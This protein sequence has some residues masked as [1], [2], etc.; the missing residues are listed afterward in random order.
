M[1]RFARPLCVTSLLF[2]LAGAGLIFSPRT[3]QVSA[4]PKPGTFWNVDDIRPGMKGTGLTVMK[5]TKIESFD[6]EVIGVLKNTNPG[7][8]MVLCRLSGLGLEKTGV[9]QGMSGSPVYVDNKLVGAVAYAWAFGKEPLAGVT[10]FSQMHE[11][12]ASYEKRDLAEKGGPKRIG[13]AKP[14]QLDGRSFDAVTVAQDFSEPDKTAA[15]GLWMI[16]LRTPI[17]ASNM[18]A[19]SLSFLKDTFAS[20][21]MVPM[22]GGGV[23]GNIPDEDRNAAIVPGAA[24]SVAMV[25]GD[26]DMSGIGT[27][28]HVEGKRV[29]G[30]GHPFFGLGACDFPL[31]T[32]YTHA[33]CAR[34]NNSFKIGA[35]LKSVGVINADVSTCIAGWLDKHPDMIP[36][37]MTVVR[38]GSP[39]K[40]YNV[41]IARQRSM[42]SGLLQAVLTN[43]VDTEGDLPDE[44]TANLK[45][46]IDVDGKPPIVIHD[47]FSGSTLAGNRAPQALFSTVGLLVNQM[48]FN[49]FTNLRI[50]KVECV[51]E[52]YPGRRTAEIDAVEM[53]SDTYAP[54]ETLKANVFLRT[55][56][57]GRVRVPV[58]LNLP[59]DLPEGTYAATVSDDIACARQELRDNP[60]LSSPQN[61]DQLWQSLNIILGAKR[62]TLAVRLQTPASGVAVNGKALPNLPGSMVQILGSG[63]RSGS[64]PLSSA[65]VNRHA[66]DWV[67]A[68]AE[69]MRFT[70]TKNKKFAD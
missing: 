19:N 33:I 65:I 25:T 41:K 10:P 31:M 34:V 8:D 35:P 62:T 15:D 27:V 69:A 39:D 45:V 23:S 14:I 59:A 32:G 56:K 36:V 2:L 28:T 50:G 53:E 9:I 60:L 61:I 37:S 4:Q 51:A 57:G 6:V 13:L 1:T 47:L 24:L 66:T 46:R 58:S 17:T 43:S 30:W 54:G 21:G 49:S 67:V 55:F 42:V 20:N 29:Y 52:I 68:G 22:Q 16:P 63:R 64:Q 48:H 11:F 5:G 3:P 7:R 18:S 26:F 12:V 40:T 44:M 70:V 38:N